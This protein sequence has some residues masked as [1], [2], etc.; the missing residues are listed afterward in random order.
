MRA[1][2]RALTTT[3]ALVVAG[4]LVACG[5]EPDAAPE[6]RAADDA[7]AQVVDSVFPMDVMLARFRAELT[8]PSSLGRGADSRDAL[9]EAVVQALQAADTTA[10]EGLAV[11]MAEWAWLYYPTSV[12]ALP[13]YELPPGMAWLQLQENNRRGALRALERLGGHELAYGGYACDPEPTLEGDNKLWIGCL[14]NLGV[15]GAEPAPTRLFSAIL[16]RDGRFAVLSFAN[17]F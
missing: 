4:L 11:D 10:F 9:V 8:E 7:P 15:D 3:L 2:T 5:G 12:Q 6:T 1:H 13:P 17:D 14:V 16:E